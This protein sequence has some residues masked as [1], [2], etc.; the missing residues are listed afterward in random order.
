MVLDPE[1]VESAFVPC[2]QRAMCVSGQTERAWQVISMVDKGHIPSQ[3]HF[4]KICLP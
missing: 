3:V 2:L 1:N 4:S